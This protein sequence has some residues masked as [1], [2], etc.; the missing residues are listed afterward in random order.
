MGK[1]LL[2]NNK[3]ILLFGKKLSTFKNAKIVKAFKMVSMVT[4][5]TLENGFYNCIGKGLT[6][7]PLL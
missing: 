3:N 2:I 1:Y 4:V 5:F 6:L 7:P